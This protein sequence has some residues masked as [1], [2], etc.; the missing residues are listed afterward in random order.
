MYLIAVQF[1][2]LCGKFCKS[3]F[4]CMH[5]SKYQHQTTTN[6]FAIGGLETQCTVD[7]SSRGVKVV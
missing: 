7:L 3:Q 4:D 5:V 6:N 2:K 1:V